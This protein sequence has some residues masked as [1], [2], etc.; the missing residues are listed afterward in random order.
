M[1]GFLAFSSCT[2]HVARRSKGSI[3]TTDANH[4]IANSLKNDVF[5]DA[6]RGSIYIS[7]KVYVT[8]RHK[9]I[10]IAYI[11]ALAQVILR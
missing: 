11:V 2:R 4:T 5:D 7:I 6:S 3:S 1:N 9:I 8:V 10:G